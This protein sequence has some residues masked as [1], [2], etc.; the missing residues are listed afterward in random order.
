MINLLVLKQFISYLTCMLLD[1]L[2]IKTTTDNV[3][4]RL[5]P[6]T[7][8]F[9]LNRQKSIEA[10]MEQDKPGIDVAEL[11]IIKYNSRELLLS[12]LPILLKNFY[13]HIKF[14]KNRP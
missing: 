6:K 7:R 1:K 12:E 10:I 3:T 5:K 2:I 13:L 14:I 9:K 4:S 11:L 8:F